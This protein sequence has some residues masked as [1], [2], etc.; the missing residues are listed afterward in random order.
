MYVDLM[1][2]LDRNPLPCYSKVVFPSIRAYQNC[3][4]ASAIVELAL[5]VSKDHDVGLAK[6][7]V[8]DLIRC[9][10]LS[11]YKWREGQDHNVHLEPHEVAV[12][13]LVERE[14]IPRRMSP[15]ELPYRPMTRKRG[16]LR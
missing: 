12:V 16:R 9:T 4:W 15:E 5:W 14:V 11:R 3:Q 13:V 7:K 8:T 1:H 6:R 2:Y 10:C